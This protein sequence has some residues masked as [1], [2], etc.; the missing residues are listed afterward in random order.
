MRILSRIRVRRQDGAGI[1]AAGVG[2]GRRPGEADGAGPV[3][4]YVEAARH[5]FTSIFGGLVRGRRDWQL[6][7]W[8]L[9]VL[10][11]IV[12]VAYVRLA[13]TSRLVPYVVQVDR[14]GQVVGAGAAEPMR[15]P[16]E[17]L[18]AA[19]LARF[20]RSIRT[21]LPSAAQA[22]QA[23]MLRHGYAFAGPE[24][25]S[26]LNQYFARPDNDPRV[27]GSRLTRQVEVTSVLRVPRSDVWTL[28]WREA[29]T[30]LQ[31]GVPPQTTA[32]EA[33]A[34]VRVVPPATTEGIEENPLGLYVTAITWTPVATGTLTS[35]AAGPSVR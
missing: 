20:L 5:E 33:Y 26:F 9:A 6:M 25:A 30:P 27:L 22:A 28:R 14:L 24:A 23:E 8:A 34:T 7:S 12:T 16:D 4:G 19:E 10:L 21:V 3:P 15:A 32:W 29:D 31:A 11:V 13:T 35:T 2:D 1:E 18:I 17:R